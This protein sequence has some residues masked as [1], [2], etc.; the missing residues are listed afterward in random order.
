MAGVDTGYV[1][2]LVELGILRPDN[3]GAFSSGDVRR[4][5]WIESLESAGVPLDEMAAAVRR[6]LFHSP[7]SIRVPSIA[8]WDWLAPHSDR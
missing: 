2:M 1:D 3:G 5:R 8:S 7:S 6:E 4:A